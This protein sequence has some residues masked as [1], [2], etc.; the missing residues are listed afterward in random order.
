MVGP[1]SCQVQLRWHLERHFLKPKETSPVVSWLGLHLPMWR[2]WV[3][4]LIGELRFPRALQPENQNVK[5]KQYCN[6][7]N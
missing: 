3:Q 4:S 7:F 5:Q 1:E 6:K 2:V